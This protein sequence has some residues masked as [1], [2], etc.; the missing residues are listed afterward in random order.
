MS[1]LPWPYQLAFLGVALIFLVGAKQLLSEGMG[2]PHRID[3]YRC[4]VAVEAAVGSCTH[5]EPVDCE[6]I[7]KMIPSWA[8]SD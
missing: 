3:V 5:S 6:A 7:A 8:D 4:Q 1:P 2:I